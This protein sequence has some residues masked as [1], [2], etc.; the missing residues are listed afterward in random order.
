[1][2]LVHGPQEAWTVLDRSMSGSSLF[3]EYG[4]DGDGDEM[5]R[6]LDADWDRL[7]KR[8]ALS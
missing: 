1:M 4:V 3:Q 2:C 6:K 8:S 7:A 5:L